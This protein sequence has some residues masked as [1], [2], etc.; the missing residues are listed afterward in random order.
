M[1]LPLLFAT[2]TLIFSAASLAGEEFQAGKF[3]QQNCTGC[4][5]SNIYTRKK[6]RIDSLPRLASQVRM[7]DANLGK[8]LFENEI[9]SLTDYLNENYYHF[10]K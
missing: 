4:H 9:Q 3:H 7:C 5:D 1:R 2:L 10:D 6:R 8:K